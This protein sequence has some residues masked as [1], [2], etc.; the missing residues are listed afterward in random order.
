VLFRFDRP[1]VPARHVWFVDE[2]PKGPTGMIL[3]REIELST[4]RAATTV[5]I[6]W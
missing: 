3:R 1:R 6:G 5:K 4:Q 2:L